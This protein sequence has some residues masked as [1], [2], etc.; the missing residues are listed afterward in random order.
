MIIC[1]TCPLFIYLH[2]SMV[3]VVIGEVLLAPILRRSPKTSRHL[4]FPPPLPGARF[5]PGVVG[6][7][8]PNIALLCGVPVGSL[9]CLSY[10]GE[11]R[12]REELGFAVQSVCFFW[13]PFRNYCT[14][15]V[16]CHEAHRIETRSGQNT[17]FCSNCATPPFL[18][19]IQCG[20]GC[21]QAC[22]YLSVLPQGSTAYCCTKDPQLAIETT[23]CLHCPK[24]CLLQSRCLYVTICTCMSYGL[25]LSPS[26]KSFFD[27]TPLCCISHVGSLVLSWGYSVHGSFVSACESTCTSSKPND[28][29]S[30]H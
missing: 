11:D 29:Q 28:C 30:E 2:D 16:P 10:T 22:L 25:G 13:L 12:F 24:C 17:P 4:R 3:F 14:G 23:L 27:R 21:A 19:A 18:H 26:P 9:K 15:M 5:W 7:I 8:R 6:A 1:N 20:F